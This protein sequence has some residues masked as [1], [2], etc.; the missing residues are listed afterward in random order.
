MNYFLDGRINR[1]EVL[2]PGVACFLIAV[3]LGSA[4]HKS[5]DKDIKRKLQLALKEQG[6]TEELKTRCVH[7]DFRKS[8]HRSLTASVKQSVKRSRIEQFAVNDSTPTF[9]SISPRIDLMSSSRG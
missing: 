9:V 6:S 4:L 8:V 1:A 2:F 3:C 7:C 5:N